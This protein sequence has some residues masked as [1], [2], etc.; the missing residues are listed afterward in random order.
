MVITRTGDAIDS[1]ILTFGKARSLT[2]ETSLL[3]KARIIESLPASAENILSVPGNPIADQLK[4]EQKQL[5]DMEER[6]QQ[7]YMAAQKETS[8]LMEAY[9]QARA[10]ELESLLAIG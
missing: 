7:Q 8:V 10:D 9:D 2:V 6:A 4:A 1:L 3:A 5:K